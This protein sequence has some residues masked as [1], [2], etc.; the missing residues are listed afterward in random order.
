MNLQTVGANEIVCR[1]RSDNFTAPI[2]ALVLSI[3]FCLSTPNFL[4]STALSSFADSTWAAAGAQVAY[5]DGYNAF[6][7]A[8]VNSCQPQDANRSDL[9]GRNQNADISRAHGGLVG[10]GCDPAFDQ[11][12]EDHTL[13]YYGHDQAKAAVD[14]AT[15]YTG[16][17][18]VAFYFFRY[19]SLQKRREL[20]ALKIAMSF[21]KAF[22]SYVYCSGNREFY[23]QQLRWSGCGTLRGV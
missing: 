1:V 20:T 11:V 23:C 18:G 5:W 22:S 6:T 16:V 7:Y 9:K 2:V 19:K 13:T 17:L 4:T 3:P 21:F 15:L 8:C 12:N 14:L 10:A